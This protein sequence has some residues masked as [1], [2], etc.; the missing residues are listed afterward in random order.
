[1]P[2][3]KVDRPETERLSPPA[4][5]PP[6]LDAV[7]PHE[8]RE[9]EFPEGKGHCDLCGGGPDAKI[10]HHVD[11]MERIAAHLE[12]IRD[13]VQR[14]ATALEKIADLMDECMGTAQG[15]GRVLDVRK[16]RK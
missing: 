7:P 16:I 3:E 6:I 14:G 5:R 13:D 15:G 9:S 8:F 12:Q 10:H 4:D 1:M 11:P 2:D